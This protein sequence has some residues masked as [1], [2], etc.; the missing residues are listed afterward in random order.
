MFCKGGRTGKIPARRWPVSTSLE[1]DNNFA[2]HHCLRLS[3][4]ISCLR[5]VTAAYISLTRNKM[6][7]MACAWACQFLTRLRRGAFHARS[8][9]QRQQQKSTPPSPAISTR[10]RVGGEAICSG[11]VIDQREVH[12]SSVIRRQAALGFENT[13]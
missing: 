10:A 2:C 4:G 13:L 11:H 12:L 6:A 1:A 5:N 9:W 3:A 7:D 8:N